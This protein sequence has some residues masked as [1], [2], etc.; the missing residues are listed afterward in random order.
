LH[1]LGS[2]VPAIQD[3]PLLSFDSAKGS[4]QLA[5]VEQILCS[6]AAAFVGTDGSVS[7]FQV[8]ES[9]P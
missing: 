4:L 7:G 3:P 1:F 8:K 5:L 9:D 2:H 6:H